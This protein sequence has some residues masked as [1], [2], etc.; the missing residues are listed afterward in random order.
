MAK[1]AQA[2]EERVEKVEKHKV[3]LTPSQHQVLRNLAYDE[4]TTI[5]FQ[6]R[7]AVDRYLKWRMKRKT[8]AA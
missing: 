7:R 3:N 1:K 6:I 5:S 8:D 2:L 4:Q